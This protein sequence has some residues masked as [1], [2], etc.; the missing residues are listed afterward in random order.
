MHEV[1]K[2]CRRLE[3]EKEEMAHALDEAEV[4]L[5]QVSYILRHHTYKDREA[6]C[7]SLENFQS[8]PALLMCSCCTV[9]KTHLR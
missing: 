1:E 9:K 3:E 5:E 7:P 2:Q 8:D 6:A 4:A